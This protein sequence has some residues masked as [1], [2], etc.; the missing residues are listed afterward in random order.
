MA[1][2]TTNDRN[3]SDKESRRTKR[4]NKQVYNVLVDP[5]QLLEGFND[6]TAASFYDNPF[7]TWDPVVTAD[8]ARSASTSTP[9][10]KPH[11]LPSVITLQHVPSAVVSHQTTLTVP[12]VNIDMSLTEISDPNFRHIISQCIKQHVFRRCK[13]YNKEHHGAYNEKPSSF[14]GIVLKV[15]HI[16][17]NLQW[18]YNTRKMIVITHTNHR[19]NCIKSMKTKFGGTLIQKHWHASC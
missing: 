12:G 14:C 9:V 3:T 7:A 8:M 16:V 4:Q 13:F 6:T 18:W 15:C 2:P 11:S 5:T 10:T 19:N 17:A 1:P